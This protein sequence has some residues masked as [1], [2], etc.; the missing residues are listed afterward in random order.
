MIPRYRFG[1]MPTTAGPVL[2]ARVGKQLGKNRGGR[3]GPFSPPGGGG[4]CCRGARFKEMHKRKPLGQ[5]GNCW[6]GTPLFAWAPHKKALASG[7]EWYPRISLGPLGRKDNRGLSWGRNPLYLLGQTPVLDLRVGD[8]PT[9][10]ESSPK[11][12][13]STPGHRYWDAIPY[14]GVPVVLAGS[15]SPREGGL[16]FAQAILSGLWGPDPKRRRFFGCVL[17]AISGYRVSEE[18]KTG[19]RRR[20]PRKVAGM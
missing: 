19:T 5:L 12:G 18:V 15:G 14:P 4:Q 7:D 11:G 20:R 16:F 8:D 10:L 2:G 9:P 1:R 6:G 17:Q 3:M 13:Q